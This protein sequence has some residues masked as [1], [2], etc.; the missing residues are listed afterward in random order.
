MH[1]QELAP[2]VFKVG[3]RHTWS[4]FYLPSNGMLDGFWSHPQTPYY[5]STLPS[6]FVER[7]HGALVA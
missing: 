7:A 3:F 1:L 2:E 5:S 6:V 4:L